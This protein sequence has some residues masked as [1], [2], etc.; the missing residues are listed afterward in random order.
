M[1]EVFLA[2]QLGPGGFERRVALKKLLPHLTDEPDC[3]AMFL[4]EAR[5]AAQ[6]QHRNITQIYEVGKQEGDFFIVME[7]VNGPSLRSLMRAEVRELKSQVPLGVAYGIT[8]AVLE[9]LAYAHQVVDARGRKLSV[10]HRD[11]TPRN[12]M[13]TQQ[14]EV[15]LLDFGIARAETQLHVTKTG[16]VKGTMP[17]MAPEQARGEEVDHRCDLYSVGAILYEM[18]TGRRAYPKGP[19]TGTP[20]SVR[21]LRPEVPSAVEAVVECSLSSN[22]SDR[23]PSAER[24]H[25]V[26]LSSVSPILVA[27]EAEMAKWVQRMILASSLSSGS[28]KDEKTEVSQDFFKDQ[29]PV[30][31]PE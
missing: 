26:L 20:K 6:L 31:L 27:R 22:S 9:A 15:K 30:D 12:I 24:M 3:V 14:G 21:R 8:S 1:A 11:V 13:L 4:D 19:G 29:K 25:K 17:Y 2:W 10:V 16:V 23:Y 18:L 7:Y 5:I 28:T